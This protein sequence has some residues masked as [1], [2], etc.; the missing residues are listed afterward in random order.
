MTRELLAERAQLSPNTVMAVEQGRVADPGF[1]T[2]AALAQ[3]LSVGLDELAERSR[4]RGEDTPMRWG[5]VSVRYEGRT[6][7]QLVADLYD[8][9][10]KHLVDVRLTPLSRKPG[11]SKCKLDAGITYRHM[12]GLGNLAVN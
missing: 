8:L 11:L 9:E 6:A 4:Q 1:F 3:A 7:G 2:V 5:V 12:P 10:V